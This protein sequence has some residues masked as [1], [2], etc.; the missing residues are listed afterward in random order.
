MR[1][2]IRNA[3]NVIL[4]AADDLTLSDVAAGEGWR[5]RHTHTGNATL[6]HNVAF[7][8]QFVAG[9]FAYVEGAVVVVNAEA[10]TNQRRPSAI[11]RKRSEIEAQYKTSIAQLT[12]GYDS[13][14]ISSWPQQSEEA[15]A[16]N[17]NPNAEVP[18]VSAI[19]TARGMELS[20]MVTRI[21]Q[22]EALFK[23]AFGTILGTKQ[24][25]LLALEAAETLEQIQAV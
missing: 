2:I 10:I 23:P 21:L 18:L 15:R 7:N 16:R 3:D 14:E 20:E 24:G 1:L 9:A 13:Y 5:D 12:A 8:H 6:V 22:K 19:A 11:K 17:A 25:R 4:Y